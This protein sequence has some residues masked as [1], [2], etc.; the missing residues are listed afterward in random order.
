MVPPSSE[1][2]R[3]RERERRGKIEN[4]QS[5]WYQLLIASVRLVCVCRCQPRALPGSRLV[6]LNRRGWFPWVGKQCINKFNQ[7]NH[8]RYEEWCLWFY[9]QGHR[10]HR[11]CFLCLLLLFSLSL[12]CVFFHRSC[13]VK[14]N[15]ILVKL[16]INLTA[17]SFVS[18]FIFNTHWLHIQV[19]RFSS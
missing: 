1:K 3:L 12:L 7:D 4:H 10:R 13:F 19:L 8:I 9:L 11:K 2:D 5:W 16:I 14:L 6:L 17:V 18:F 15:G